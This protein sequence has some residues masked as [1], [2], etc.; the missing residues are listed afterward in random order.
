MS[1]KPTKTR[2]NTKVQ[3]QTHFI[4]LFNTFYYSDSII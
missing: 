2:K 1:T 4:F 3:T